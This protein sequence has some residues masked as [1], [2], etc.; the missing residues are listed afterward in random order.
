MKNIWILGVLLVSTACGGGQKPIDYGLESCSHCQMIISQTGYGCEIVSNTGKTYVFDA[1]ECMINF[2][3][4]GTIQKKDIKSYLV[5]HINDPGN[6]KD[7]SQSRFI[8]SPNLPSPMGMYITAVGSGESEEM[9]Q[10][11]GGEVYDWDRL[12][13][14]F[15]SLPRIRK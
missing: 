7:A 13:T 9:Q 4:N 1:I 11:H 2:V 10:K 3:G 6:L 12:V 5:T 8:R 14:E 15:K